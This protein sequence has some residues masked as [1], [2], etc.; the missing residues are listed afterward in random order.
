ML[1]ETELVPYSLSMPPGER[2][3]VLAPHPDDETFGM[4][5]SL[6]LLT[7]SGKQVKV[8]V[9]TSGEKADP[10]VTEKQEYSSTRKKE[11]LKAFRLLGVTDCEFLGF[12]DR[13]LLV[14]RGDVKGAI[15]RIVSAFSPD[16]IY[17]PSLIELH[18]DHRIAA[19]LAYEISRG[20]KAV[21]CVYYEITTLVRPNILVDI[22]KTFKWKKKA[23][24]CYKSQ[25]KLVDYPGLMEAMNRYRT[26]TLGKGVKFAEAF[27][28]FHTTFIRQDI[29]MW[30][31]YE[32]PLVVN[33]TQRM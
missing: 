2:V 23:M 24:K 8:I 4:G 6:R 31:N 29:H 5:G 26:F 21:R 32:M 19:E 1:L 22:S 14:H 15:N 9:L 11:A 20:E 12:P 28:E 10:K 25:M 16:V 27:W 30:L 18:P 17:S 33:N 7:E 13:E 3:L